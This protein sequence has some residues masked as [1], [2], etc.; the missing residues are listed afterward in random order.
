MPNDRVLNAFNKKQTTTM[1]NK[2]KKT[3]P[4]KVN[5]EDKMS[6]VNLYQNNGMCVDNPTLISLGELWN[7]AKDSILTQYPLILSK[8]KSITT[9]LM[10]DGVLFMDLAVATTPDGR[11]EL[12]SGRH[13]AAA[14]KLWFELSGKHPK[15]FEHLKIRVL[16]YNANSKEDLANAVKRWNESRSMP[17]SEKAYIDLQS[18]GVKYTTE[19]IL[20]NADRFAALKHSAY[21]KALG[22]LTE[23]AVRTE[24]L[25]VSLTPDTALRVGKAVYRYVYSQASKEIRKELK[26][27]DSLE[28]LFGFIQDNLQA[29]EE[30]SLKEGNTNTAREGY[31]YVVDYLG[32]AYLDE[33]AT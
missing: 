4:I 33:E 25:K 30:A 13:R 5:T 6:F 1:M 28:F 22:M 10:V 19:D 26:Q 8:V 27:K 2:V 31:K 12:V 18:W 29:A 24:E 15:K 16:A 32:A 21:G 9:S 7:I 11:M 17:Q 23:R 3:G 20:Q 14:I